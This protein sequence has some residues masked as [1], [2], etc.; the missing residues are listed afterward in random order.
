MNENAVL[1]EEINKGSAAAF[2]KMTEK[3]L[4]LVR[5][6][7]KA[8]SGRGCEAD[9]LMQIGSIGLIK[10]IKRFDSSFGVK[11]STYAVPMISGEIRRFLRDDGIIKV[12]RSVKEAAYKGRAAEEKLRRELSREPTIKEVSE[13]SGISAENI[14]YAFEACSD[15]VPIDDLCDFGMQSAVESHEEQSINKIWISEGLDALESRERQVIILR[16]TK[17]LTQSKIASMLGI[18]Q[19][20]VSR[21]EK[22]AIEK[23]RVRLSGKDI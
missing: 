9:D 19:V 13:K 7:A 5:S 23:I 22:R 14:A 10:A 1:L 12:S 16:D 18:S 4:P 2:E 11:F 20:Q 3:N 6:V 21:I 8:F 17:S 15:C